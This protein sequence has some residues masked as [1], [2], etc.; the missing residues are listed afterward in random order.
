[1][2]RRAFQ[3]GGRSGA[4][5]GL[6]LVEMTVILSVIVILTTVLVPTVM[7]HIAQAR[8]I[9]AQQDVRAL[10]NALTRFFDDTGFMPTT[11]D[12]INGR[13]GNLTLDLLITP[14]EAPSLPDDATASL[15]LWITGRGDYFRNHLVNNTPGYDGDPNTDDRFDD[16]PGY[17][18]MTF[19]TKTGWDGPY[20]S[21]PEADPWGNRYMCNVIYLKPGTGVVARDGEVKRT[22][23]IIS[24]GPDGIIQTE[25]EQLKTNARTKG[26]DIAYR[27]Q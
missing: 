13:P 18:L 16:I 5:S 26:D 23:L 3:R 1:M 6:T 15:Q 22:V 21:L 20:I 25:F 4:R 24:A 12:V 2:T 19:E 9:R 10:A 8:V 27:Y 17:R 14:G 11:S 7:S